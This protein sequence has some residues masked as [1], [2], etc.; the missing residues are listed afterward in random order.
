MTMVP[1]TYD[2][3]MRRVLADEGGYSNDAADPGGPTKYGITIFDVR[4][5][6]KSNATAADVRAL[7]IPDAMDIYRK[8]YA[9]PVRY[10]ELAAGVDYTVLDYAINSGIARVP[11]VVRRLVGLQ[12]KGPID[13]EVLRA[14]GKRDAKALIVAINDERLRFLKSLRTWPVFGKGWGRR[15]AGVNNAALHMVGAVEIATPP[16]APAPGKGTVP[17][18]KAVKNVVKGGGPAAA[19]E[20]AARDGAG[21]MDWIAAHPKTS[22]LIVIVAIAT[23]AF[24]INRINAWHKHKSE[25]PMPGLVPVPELPQAGGGVLSTRDVIPRDPVTGEIDEPRDR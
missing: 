17:E 13:D 19:A 18:P 3:A 14:V 2:Q 4:K 22:V 12:G 1:Q 10:D 9:R 15:V 16:V 24:I 11:N 25:E 7:T 8:H 23:V 21:W 5:Y 20:E 6:R